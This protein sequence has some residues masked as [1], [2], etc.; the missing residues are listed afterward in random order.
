MIGKFPSAA[1][2]FFCNIPLLQN[3]LQMEA[4][5]SRLKWRSDAPQFCTGG[6]EDCVGFCVFGH[7]GVYFRVFVDAISIKNIRGLPISTPPLSVTKNKSGLGKYFG[8][9]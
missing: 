4:S 8:T 9:K 7:A 3:G 1:E 6:G 5:H 2:V